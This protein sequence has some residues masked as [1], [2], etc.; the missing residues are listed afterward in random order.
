MLAGKIVLVTEAAGREA[1]QGKVKGEGSSVALVDLKLD[2]STE[3]CR[4]SCF[5]LLNVTK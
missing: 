3:M 2:L 5:Q 4:E 1:G